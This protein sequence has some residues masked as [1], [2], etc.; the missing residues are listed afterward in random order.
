MAYQS[1]KSE[2]FLKYGQFLKDIC[3]QELY[4]DVSDKLKIPSSGNEYIASINF[5][6][7]HAAIKEIQNHIYGDMEIQ[8]GTCAGHNVTLTAVEYHQGSEVTIALT[9]CLLKVGKRED[10]SNNIYEES[11]METFLLRK[12]EGVEL[13]GTTL[14]YSPLKFRNAPYSTIVCLLK[15]TNQEISNHKKS[16]LVKKKNKFMLVSEEREDKIAE[17]Y[18]SGFITAKD[19]FTS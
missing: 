19:Q 5:I 16:S 15:G 3:F 1:V 13:Y 9:D 12:G 17:G 14:H 18:L 4:D 8:A 11:K 2:S 7:Q 6:E 10:I